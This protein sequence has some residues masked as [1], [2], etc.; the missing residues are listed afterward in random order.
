MGTRGSRRDRFGRFEEALIGEFKVREK[1]GEKERK[2]ELTR[3]YLEWCVCVLSCFNAF[4]RVDV[5][6]EVKIPGGVDGELVLPLPLSS[7]QLPERARRADYCSIHYYSLR[8]RSS[9]RTVSLRT[10]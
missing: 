8:D 4:S 6:V 7:S 2:F 10:R 5:R 3:V 1:L 9:R